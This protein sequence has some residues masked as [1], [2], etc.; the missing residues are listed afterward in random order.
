MLRLRLEDDALQWLLGWGRHVRVLGP[1][2]LRRRVAAEASAL[3]QHHT[4]V[5]Q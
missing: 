3:W 2:S 4:E 1:E 5:G